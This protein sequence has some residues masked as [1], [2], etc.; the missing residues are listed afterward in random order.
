[1]ATQFEIGCAKVPYGCQIGYYQSQEFG[2][3]L[4]DMKVFEK[5]ATAPP[6]TPRA[7]R[8]ISIQNLGRHVNGH[9]L[10]EHLRLAGTLER[11]DMPE[12][13]QATATF[14]TE[15]EAKRAVQLLSDI[16]NKHLSLG[17]YLRVRICRDGF[18]SPRSESNA[19]ED[20]ACSDTRS[21]E[22]SM[23]SNPLAA[24]AFQPYHQPD[25]ESLD[26]LKSSHI[27]RRDSG[28]EILLEET[29]KLSPSLPLVVNGS[30]FGRKASQ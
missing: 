15:E 8:T 29:R 24:E 20:T 16:S 17:R 10:R 9:M 21:A 12:K 28:K 6:N 27:S 26:T 1:M 3:N 14:Y 2:Y 25:M 11:C 18:S 13:G 30:A 5:T 7:N 19:S 23:A 22:L 4:L